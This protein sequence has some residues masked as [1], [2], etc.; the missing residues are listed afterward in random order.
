MQYIL[1]CH[2]RDDYLPPSIVLVVALKAACLFLERIWPKDACRDVGGCPR[3]KRGF[4]SIVGHFGGVGGFT[5][6]ICGH[7]AAKILGS[8]HGGLEKVH[9]QPS[10]DLI[11]GIFR[12][13][14]LEFT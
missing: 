1:E 6:S 9:V 2:F 3:T 13:L 5:R 7:V 12:R 8:G 4:R 10:I 11:F 14:G